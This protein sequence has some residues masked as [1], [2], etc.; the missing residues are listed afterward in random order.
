MV[1]CVVGKAKCC[2]VHNWPPKLQKF[3]PLFHWKIQKFSDLPFFSWNTTQPF[4]KK[5]VVDEQKRWCQYTLQAYYFDND[6]Q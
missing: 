6:V 3:T 2:T 5:V 4:T 1:E